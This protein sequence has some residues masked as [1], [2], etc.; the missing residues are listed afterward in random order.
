MKTARRTLIVVG[1]LLLAYGISGAL[2]DADLGVGALVFLVAVLVLHDALFLPLTIGAG[3]LIGWL[4]P[5][6]LRGTVRAA[7]VIS[8]AVTVVALP[9]VLGRGRVPDNPSVLPLRYGTGLLLSYAAIWLVAG[10]VEAAR[11]WR[12]R[13]R[14]GSA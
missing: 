9:L 14:P 3:A 6:A 12:R 13:V 10:L 5:S 11:R 2:S 8:L 1:A 4:V 7:A